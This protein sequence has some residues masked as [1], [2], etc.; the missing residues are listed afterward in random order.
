MKWYQ[1]A[2]NPQAIA[3]LFKQQPEL[4]PLKL[5]KIAL[6]L[7]ENQLSLNLDL[8]QFPDIPPSSW[9]PS[10]NT[11]QV[12]LE[13]HSVKN[14]SI[15]S[16]VIEEVFLFHIKQAAPALICLTAT[17]SNSEI[18]LEAKRFRIEHMSSYLIS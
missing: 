5:M 7:P 15:S 8:P 6:H 1:L 9:H 14:I 12:Q 4:N 11:A 16:Y 13:F 17:S 2:E 10:N 3:A 18:K